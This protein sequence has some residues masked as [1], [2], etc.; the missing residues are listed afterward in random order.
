MN[1][2]VDNIL[3]AGDKFMF[4]LHLRQPA[5]T[6]RLIALV[7][8]SPNTVKESRNLKKVII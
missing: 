6:Y 7:D 1:E 2:I 8:H 4:K 3:M 5:L